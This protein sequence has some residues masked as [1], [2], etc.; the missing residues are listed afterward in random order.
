MKRHRGVK[1]DLKKMCQRERG[2]ERDR[3]KK[4]RRNRVGKI[5]E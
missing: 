5:E 3:E 1:R 4:R 2:R